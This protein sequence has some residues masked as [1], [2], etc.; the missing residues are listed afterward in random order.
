MLYFARRY[1][2]AI[3]QQ[4]KAIALEPDSPL[5]HKNLAD[6]LTQ[7]RMFSEALVEIDRAVELAKGSA[8]LLDDAGYVYAVSGKRDKAK[9]VL[10]QLD[11]LSEET[12][13]PEYGRAVIYTGLGDKDKAIEWLEKA[14]NQRCFL[15]WLKVDPIFDPLR[16]DD[17]FHTLLEKLGLG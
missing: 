2:E 8:F 14:Y 13:T 1:D 15:T 6:V 10:G 17:R 12:Y 16:D 9:R 4:K 7:K 5:Y 11:E 3:E